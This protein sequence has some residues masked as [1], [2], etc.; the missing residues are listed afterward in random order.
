MYDELGLLKEVGSSFREREGKDRSIRYEY[1]S[2]DRLVKIVY[3]EGKQEETFRYDSWGKLLEATKRAGDEK[4]VATYR[5]DYF[6]RLIERTERVNDSAAVVML[7][8]YNPW[9]QRTV[10][11]FRNGS[12]HRV[13]EK[14]YD[15]FGRLVEIQ[16]EEGRVLYFYNRRNQLEKRLVNNVPEFYY[17]TKYGQLK[18]KSLGARLSGR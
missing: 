16:S 18:A 5:Y 10:R 6:N 17:Y 13:E 11:V 7:Y 1:D 8:S 4:R 15:E 2:L 14:K 3:D 12:L 9:D